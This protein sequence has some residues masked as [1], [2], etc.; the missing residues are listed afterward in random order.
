MSAVRV[1]AEGDT[2]VV[3]FEHPLLT[4]TTLE[5]ATVAIAGAGSRH[6]AVVIASEHPRIFLAGAHL[7]EIAGLD[8]LSSDTYSR[9]GCRLMKTVANLPVPVVAAVH[10]ACAGGGLDLVMACD[11]ISA[12][13]DARF[14][15]P[16]VRR[17]LITGWSGTALLRRRLGKRPAVAL[18]AA[19]N[20]LSA[21]A[22][23]AAGLVDE[24]AEEAEKAALRRADFLARLSPRRLQAWRAAR[25]GGFIDIFGVNVV[26]TKR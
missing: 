11:W 16:G 22:A 25:S 7:E 19:G 13:D 8:H 3:S 2:A 1:R 26:H 17:G 23:M 9:L 20:M 5:A 24:L 12:E 14:G 15:H 10:G 4:Q 18:L 6:R 21:N